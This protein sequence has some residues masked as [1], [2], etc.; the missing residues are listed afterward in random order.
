VPEDWHRLS[1]QALVQRALKSVGGAAWHLDERDVN[2]VFSGLPPA[3]NAHPAFAQSAF[4]P[5]ASPTTDPLH[6]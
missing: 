2:L 3:S 4:A 5:T 1:A 6:A